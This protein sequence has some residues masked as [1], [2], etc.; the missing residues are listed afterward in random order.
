MHYKTCPLNE[1]P[2]GYYLPKEAL[3]RLKKTMHFWADKH[4]DL[5]FDV[6]ATSWDL[7]TFGSLTPVK[8]CQEAA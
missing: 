5:N 1:S 2:D 7:T 8:Q 6:Q 4:P 3:V